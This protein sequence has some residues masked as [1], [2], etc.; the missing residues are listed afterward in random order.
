MRKPWFALSSIAWTWEVTFH[1]I[2]PSRDHARAAGPIGSG[3]VVH[4]TWFSVHPEAARTASTRVP[5]V[6]SDENRYSRADAT[7]HPSG[8]PFGIAKV[9]RARARPLTMPVSTFKDPASTLRMESEPLVDE[10][11]FS[12]SH[13]SDLTGAV[14]VVSS[15]SAAL[16]M[17]AATPRSAPSA[18]VS[19]MPADATRR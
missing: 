7:T 10:G 12:S 8:T 3:C 17:P 18:T 15:Q 1:R 11:L 5:S 16:E 2:Y 9:T 19:A 6:P 13:A 4:V 14:T